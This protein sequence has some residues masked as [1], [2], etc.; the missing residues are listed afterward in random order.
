MRGKQWGHPLKG[1]PARKSGGHSKG[2][3]SPSEKIVG[4]RNRGIKEFRD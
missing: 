1:R 2:K 4:F 3:T